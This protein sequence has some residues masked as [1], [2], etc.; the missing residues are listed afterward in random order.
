[1]NRDRDKE[2]KDRR[3]AG[4]TLSLA[5]AGGT[6]APPVWSQDGG[7]RD[8]PRGTAE[9]EQYSALRSN[10]KQQEV[11]HQANDGPHTHKERC[12]QNGPKLKWTVKTRL[13]HT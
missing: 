7:A 1:M 4:A 11:A 12:H 9:A 3:E 2:R 5:D 10:R 6:G 13:A 8:A